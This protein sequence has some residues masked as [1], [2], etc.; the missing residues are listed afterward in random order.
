MTALFL[1]PVV[2]AAA[3]G[4][5]GVDLYLP[6][7]AVQAYSSTFS[8]R[9]DGINWAAAQVLV[10]S[11]TVA[12]QTFTD[13]QAAT[14][15][16]T[17][18]N[19]LGLS[20]A[21]A[22]DKITIVTDSAGSLL[23]SC[24]SGGGPTVGSFNACNPANYAIT[25][26][27]NTDC[28]AIAAA[29]TSFNVLVA[30]CPGAGSVIYTTSTYGGAIWNQFSLASSTQAALQ[31]G[32]L[33]SSNTVPGTGIGV[34]TGGSNNATFS[35]NGQTFTANQLGSFGFYPVTSN[36]QT[37][38][39]IATAITNSSTTI[40]VVAGAGGSVVFATAT[41]TGVVGNTYATF[42]SSD[43]ALTL[44]TYVSSGP[45]VA[46][47][48]MS[49]G[50]NSSYALNSA[51]ISIPGN[52]FGPAFQVWLSTTGNVVVPAPLVWGT[53]Y[54][55]VVSAGIG[56]GNIELATT[57][58]LAVAG[59]GLVLTSSQ[60]KTTADVFTL[61]PL[62][63]TGTPSTQWVV[64]TDNV[65]WVPYTTTPFGQT[66]NA[67]QSYGTYY[68]TGTL[69]TSDLGHMDYGWIGLNVTAPTTGAITVKAKISGDQ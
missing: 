44:S 31:V 4:Q 28:Q 3:G 46:S 2:H 40:G 26:T 66:I 58:A 39:N 65:S 49:G 9:T 67:L 52:T 33:V 10:T 30:T 21:T 12:A 47:G 16:L 35:I 42:V 63:I 53:T 64:S 14:A 6:I 22:T 61:N 57:S 55:A 15:T 18:G 38:T 41:V 51:V 7:N 37:A 5:Q 45:T 56:I 20:T 60:T 17:V 32:N 1:C 59:S 43:P 11:A 54:Y 8:V 13:G 68:A 29:I 36:G 62:G 19:Y 69:T 48:F 34:L 27:A 25:G 24:I 50:S 23:G